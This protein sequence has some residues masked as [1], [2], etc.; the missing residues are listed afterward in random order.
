MFRRARTRGPFLLFGLAPRRDAA[1]HSPPKGL[2]SVAL[3]VT[4]S[5]D[6]MPQDYLGALSFG[7]RTFLPHDE[8][9]GAVVLACFL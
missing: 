9:I 4:V 6:T 2:V 1:F 7:A 8:D 5:E 3:F